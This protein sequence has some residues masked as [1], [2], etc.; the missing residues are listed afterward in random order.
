MDG[1]EYQP[2]EFPLDLLGARTVHVDFAA[3]MFCWNRVAETHSRL[4][5]CRGTGAADA[6]KKKQ[7]KTPLSPFQRPNAEPGF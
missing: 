3:L 2:P 5:L 7:K 1:C 6:V 4:V